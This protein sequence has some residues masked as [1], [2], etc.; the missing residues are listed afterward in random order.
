MFDLPLEIWSL[1]ADR[2][3]FDDIRALA[4]TCTFLR[5]LPRQTFFFQLVVE[6]AR[7]TYEVTAAGDKLSIGITWGKSTYTMKS[8]ILDVPRYPISSVAVYNFAACSFAPATFKS[9]LVARRICGFRDP[10]NVQDGCVVLR[11]WLRRHA[12][13]DDDR[14]KAQ[15]RMKKYYKSRLVYF[16]QHQVTEAD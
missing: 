7:T 13:T 12:M 3:S 1:I 9:E 15:E 6:P 10:D 5:E 16:R 14:I 11:L 2:L 4:C 8:L